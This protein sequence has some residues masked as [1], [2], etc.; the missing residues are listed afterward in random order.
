VGYSRD[1]FLGLHASVFV[2]EQ[3]LPRMEKEKHANRRGESAAW[4][5]KR[6]R[7]LTLQPVAPLAS[8]RLQRKALELRLRHR[9]SQK[10]I[11]LRTCGNRIRPIPIALP[12][13]RNTHKPG[14]RVRE[15]GT[16]WVHHFR[17][18]LVHLVQIEDS[19]LPR[20]KTCGDR[21][22]FEKTAV[23][24]RSSVEPIG[25]DADFD[26]GAGPPLAEAA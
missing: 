11:G 1:E 22:R 8:G 9:A 15:P 20:C 26:Q 2:I 18:R 7:W 19:V 24:P 6:Q 5:R 3:D 12:V 14:D 17:H 4:M 10:S 25:R 13:L 23:Q 21:V 16:Y